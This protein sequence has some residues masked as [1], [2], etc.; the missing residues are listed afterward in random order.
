[1]PQKKKNIETPLKHVF[2]KEQKKKKQHLFPKRNTENFDYLKT[3]CK[4]EK[5]T[6]N[7]FY[8]QVFGGTYG[9]RFVFGST[10]HEAWV[11]VGELEG[12][13]WWLVVVCGSC[14]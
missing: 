6:I 12:Y 7:M 3:L 10:D 5:K 4:Q 8:C 13:G 9:F 1:M 11:Y 14:L 2:V